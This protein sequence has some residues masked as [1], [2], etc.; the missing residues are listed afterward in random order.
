VL[1]D[2]KR[3]A[4][5]LVDDDPD[6]RELVVLL[7]ERQGVRVLEAAD[8]AQAIEVAERE[9]ESIFLVLLDY[10]MPGMEPSCCAG[11]LRAV[12]G[13]ATRM[14]LCTAAVDPRKRAAELCLREWLSKP[15]PIA[16]LEAIVGCGA[17]SCGGGR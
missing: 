8:C 11:K 1:S 6:F 16:T 2:P 13:E 9:R 10:S 15:F 4:V 5:L 12:L 14:V 3:P 17:A 7:L